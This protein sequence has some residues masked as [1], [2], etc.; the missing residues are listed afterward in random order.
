MS[1]DVNWTICFFDILWIYP[2]GPQDASLA[3][4]KVTTK[5]LLP[6]FEGREIPKEFSFICHLVDPKI[7]R[8]SWDSLPFLVTEV[9]PSTFSGSG[10]PIQNM[11]H[12][13]WNTQLQPTLHGFAQKIMASPTSSAS[14][15][16]KKIIQEQPRNTRWKKTTHP[17]V[18]SLASAW[19][20]WPWITH[21]KWYLLPI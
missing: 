3:S 16:G 8:S 1:N 12:S 4:R 10:R 6:F 7:L 5:G 2:R 21:K 15:P 13:I 14:L 9:L 17:T 20:F 19:K 11:N 18:V